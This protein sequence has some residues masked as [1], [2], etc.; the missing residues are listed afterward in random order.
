MQQTSP[1]ARCEGEVVDEDTKNRVQIEQQQQQQHLTSVSNNM[2]NAAGEEQ[3]GSGPKEAVVVEVH[4]EQ[5]RELQQQAPQ[6]KSSSDFSLRY[7][8][9]S[10]SYVVQQPQHQQQPQQQPSTSNA[11][12]SD[13]LPL[14]HQS[15]SDQ[16]FR[17][18]APT[19]PA[20]HN[21]QHQYYQQQQHQMQLQLYKQQQQRSA[22][23]ASLGMHAGSRNSLQA[24]APYYTAAPQVRRANSRQHLQ[25]QQ[26]Q[27][28]LAGSRQEFLFQE[29]SSS[30]RKERSW[31]F[32]SL[33][34]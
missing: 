14:L 27:H 18:M 19:H 17:T 28:Y 2:V 26:Q 25:Q 3:L 9:G 29:Y 31:G 6:F 5:P 21:V 8:S 7:R 16:R 34:C 13:T 32:V 30:S 1:A 33:S 11:T 10:N 23:L 4:R 22:S 12:T 15:S 20:L 24:T